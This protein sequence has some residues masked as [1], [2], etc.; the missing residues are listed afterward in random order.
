MIYNFENLSFQIM[1]VIE[2]SHRDGEPLVKER[3][4]AAISYKLNGEGH[5]R[6][7]G[8]CLT[9]KSGE[10]VFI[11]A[12]MP[13]QVEYSCSRT[14]VIH[15]LD[16]N[17][18]DAEKITPSDSKAIESRFLHLL[19]VWQENGSINL[20]KSVLFDILAHLEA[21]AAPKKPKSDISSCMEYIR[22]HFTDPGFTVEA[23][24][25]GEHASHSTLQRKFKRDLGMTPKQYV[26]RLRMNKALDLLSEGDRSVR[27]IAYECGYNDEKYFSKAFK[28]FYGC[29]PANFR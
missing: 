3:P 20:I 7:D 29:S 9:V 28:Q 21:D 12:D 1:N 4:Y 16:C 19:N 13:Y 15:L 24:C 14:V 25:H 17:Y 8:K 18:R 6:I 11:P 22:A 23:L 10:V 5:F 26:T 2:F 27:A